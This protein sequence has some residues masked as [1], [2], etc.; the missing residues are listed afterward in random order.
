MNA[1]AD[2]DGVID[3]KWFT[4]DGVFPI[5]ADHSQWSKA[6]AWCQC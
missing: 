3:G 5:T 1:V 2:A 4:N 6:P